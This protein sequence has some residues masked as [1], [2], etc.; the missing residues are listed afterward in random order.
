MFRN[1]TK[2][3]NAKRAFEQKTGVKLNWDKLEKTIVEYSHLYGDQGCA[4]ACESFDRDFAMSVITS[5]IEN[6]VAHK[7][8]L[9][10]MWLNFNDEVMPAYFEHDLSNE[11][12]AYKLSLEDNK[13]KKSAGNPDL[14][15]AV[16]SSL[17]FIDG[18][19]EA[20]DKEAFYSDR[21]FN[22]SER[23]EDLSTIEAHTYFTSFKESLGK[24]PTS[25]VGLVET[26]YENGDITAGSMLSDARKCAP[27][28]TMADAERI[29]SQAK[30]LENTN[31]NRSY[32]PIFRHPIKHLYEKFV[33]RQLRSIAVKNEEGK[34]IEQLEAPGIK[35]NA[36]ALEQI[37]DIQ[38]RYDHITKLNNDITDELATKEALKEQN[39]EEY[40]HKIEEINARNNNH[41]QKKEKVNVILENESTTEL[42]KPVNSQPVL[43]N[44]AIKK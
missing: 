24:L 31:K 13:S 41:E 22:P 35:T 21:S 20:T 39:K 8:S 16:D 23:L 37:N 26:R 4:M 29:A 15:A 44:Q 25:K 7:T 1:S 40:K 27:S 19:D 30:A 28:M 12:E 34:T 9:V 38:K 3:Q 14:N 42:S 5:A 33:I 10:D 6:D 2:I 43:D 17:P 36:Y 32:R 18:N 11:L